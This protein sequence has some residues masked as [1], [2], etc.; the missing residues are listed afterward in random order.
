MKFK[1]L[2]SSNKEMLRTA[3]NDLARV[4]VTIEQV[5]GA[6]NEVVDGISVIRELAEENKESANVRFW[7]N[8]REQ[9]RMR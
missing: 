1:K 3:Q 7:Q 9:R 4:M 6:S 2:F 5:K 8:I